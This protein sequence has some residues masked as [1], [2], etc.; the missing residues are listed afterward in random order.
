[1]TARS[2][3]PRPVRAYGNE[4]CLIPMSTMGG[5]AIAQAMTIIGLPAE[6]FGKELQDFG[7]GI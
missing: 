1:M 5:D 3:V 7:E 4:W 2:V 6:A